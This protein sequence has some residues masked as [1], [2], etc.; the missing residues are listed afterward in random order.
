MKRDFI[1]GIV[2]VALVF[3]GAVLFTYGYNLIPV[4]IET[5]SLWIEAASF[6][7]FMGGAILGLGALVALLSF[8]FEDVIQ[9]VE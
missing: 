7:L 8:I 1:Y 2:C 3:I 4:A 5:E 9:N 6:G